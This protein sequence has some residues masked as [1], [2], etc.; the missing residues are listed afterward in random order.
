MSSYIILP[1][2]AAIVAVGV[3][4]HVDKSTKK[5]IEEELPRIQKRRTDAATILPTTSTEP[6]FGVRNTERQI[7]EKFVGELDFIIAQAKNYE[8]QTPL[9]RALLP[10]PP[11]NDMVSHVLTQLW[12]HDDGDFYDSFD[13]LFRKKY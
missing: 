10:P 1:L 2:S 13:D 12:L 7:F 5:R 9:V 6:H 3:L 4:A 11:A 8:N